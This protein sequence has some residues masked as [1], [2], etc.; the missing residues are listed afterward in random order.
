MEV[1]IKKCN[2]SKKDFPVEVFGDNGKG[3]CFKNRIAC[4]TR[5][6]AENARS[7][8][9]QAGAKL[10]APAND[11]HTEPPAEVLDGA[12]VVDGRTNKTVLCVA[13][14]NLFVRSLFKYIGEKLP[15]FKIV[16][17]PPQKGYC[18][19]MSFTKRIGLSIKYGCTWG[20]I[21]QAVRTE[22]AM[23]ATTSLINDDTICDETNITLFIEKIL[24]SVS[25]EESVGIEKMTRGEYTVQGYGITLEDSGQ[26]MFLA[27]GDTWQRVLKSLN[28]ECPKCITCPICLEELNEDSGTILRWHECLV[29]VCGGCTVKQFLATSGLMVCCNCRHTVGEIMPMHVVNQVAEKMLLRLASGL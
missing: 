7:R 11:E 18:F 27:Y 19:T 22:L 15:D 26:K 17:E 21:K 4:R 2:K 20:S 12:P 9:K 6:R 25:P 14:K 5:G 13:N 16:C 3:G 8:L 29:G 1:I 10:G 28:Y 24:C 23:K